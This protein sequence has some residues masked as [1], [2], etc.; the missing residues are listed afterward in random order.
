MTLYQIAEDTGILPNVLRETLSP[1]DLC[2]WAVYMNS[3]FSR[4]GRDVLMNGWLVQVVRSMVADK[5]HK[6]K[7]ADSVF[8]FDKIAQEFFEKPKPVAPVGKPVAAPVGKAKPKTAAEVSHLTQVLK[9]ELE[10]K[11]ADYRAGKIPNKAGLYYGQT[12]RK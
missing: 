1:A 8:P 7:F 11:R 3:P 2:E 10:R 4:R 6:P 12:L 5:R 9:K